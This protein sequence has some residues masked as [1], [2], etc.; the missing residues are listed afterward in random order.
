MFEGGEWIV[1]SVVSPGGPPTGED[2]VRVKGDEGGV[3][4]LDTTVT[5]GAADEPTTGEVDCGGFDSRGKG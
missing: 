5:V 2:C 4:S 3:S 1:P